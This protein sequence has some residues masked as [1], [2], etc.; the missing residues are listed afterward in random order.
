VTLTAEDKEQYWVN[1]VYFAVWATNNMT[2]SD[3]ITPFEL[4]F[5]RK[6][7]YRTDLSDI[8]IQPMVDVPS[9]YDDYLKMVHKRMDELR[10]AVNSHKSSQRK[11][12]ACRMR[13]RSA[14]TANISE[15]QFCYIW[16][17]QYKSK[18][19]LSRKISFYYIGPFVC[20]KVLPDQF[21]VISTLKDEL[22]TQP[23]HIRR[24]RKAK[25]R[26]RENFADTIWQLLAFIER[27]PNNTQEEIAAQLGPLQELAEGLRIR[28][29]DK[30]PRASAIPAPEAP[31][32]VPWDLDNETLTVEPHLGDEAVEA[33]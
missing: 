7:N 30:L 16:A 18:L 22:I 33:K 28:E 26:V 19:F 1:G 17:P 4:F 31:D 3:G 23:I 24:I 21:V 6:H 20:T 9:G 2:T 25:I 27:L 5:G 11:M 10:E 29:P 12:S 8:D 15:G 32:D 14:K 13:N